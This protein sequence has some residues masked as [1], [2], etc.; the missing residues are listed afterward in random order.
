MVDVHCVV[1]VHNEPDAFRGLEEMLHEQQIRTHHA[2][3]CAA[4]RRMLSEA[5]PVDVVLTDVKLVDGTWEDIIRLVRKTARQVPVIVMSRVA[6]MKLYLDTQDGGAADFIV[7]PMAPR[8]LAHV[9]ASAMHRKLPVRK[10]D[11]PTRRT[12]HP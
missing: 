12:I 10:S 1:L 11:A 5:G 4:A 6:S 2:H 9:L 7:P 3:H 8:D